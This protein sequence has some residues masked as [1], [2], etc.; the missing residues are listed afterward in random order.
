MAGLRGDLYHR[1]LAE[2]IEAGHGHLKL[3]QSDASKFAVGKN[4]ALTPGKVI[5]Q[6]ADGSVT[7][8]DVLRP[9]MGGQERITGV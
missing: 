1:M 5:Y 8:P 6:N 9:Y 2:D 3:R 7:I 4:L